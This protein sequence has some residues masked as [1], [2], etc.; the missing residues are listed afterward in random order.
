MSIDFV[1][2]IIMRI[3]LQVVTNDII[4]IFASNVLI[5][6]G[7]IRNKGNFVLGIGMISANFQT[8]RTDLS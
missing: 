3:P 4:F 5:S 2:H 8:F 6:L 7:G 1:Q